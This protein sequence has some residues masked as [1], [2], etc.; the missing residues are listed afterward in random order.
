MRLIRFR[1]FLRWFLAGRIQRL[2]RRL[3]VVH[4]SGQ[5][6]DPATL[7]MGCAGPFGVTQM[8][9]DPQQD[10]LLQP[11]RLD[12]DL[13]AGQ[14]EVVVQAPVHQRYRIGTAAQAPGHRPDLPVFLW[15]A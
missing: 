4:I 10:C 15:E 13:H 6:V 7:V 14:S 5:N 1:G 3:N 12:R 11:Q 2:V 8:G 9:L